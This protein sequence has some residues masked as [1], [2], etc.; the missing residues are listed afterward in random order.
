MLVCLHGSQRTVT[1]SASV[2][3]R[4]L[5]KDS[6]NGVPWCRKVSR[7]ARKVSYGAKKV[8]HGAEK[9]PL[10]WGPILIIWGSVSNRGYTD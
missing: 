4:C 6:Q 10:F 7:G 8:S 9:A 3:T 2:S 5:L 1:G